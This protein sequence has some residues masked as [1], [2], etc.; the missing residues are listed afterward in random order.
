[1][2]RLKKISRMD[3]LSDTVYR[4]LYDS[5]IAGQ[6]IAGEIHNENE[7]AEQLGVSR[8]PV[9]EALRQ[10][11]SEG[12]VT[13][14]PGRGF[15]VNRFSSRDIEQI[16]KLRSVLE[17]AIVEEI[18]KNPEKYNFQKADSLHRQLCQENDALELLKI[19][20][21]YHVALCALGGNP[22]MEAVLNKSRDVTNIFRKGNMLDSKRI[23]QI[24]AEHQRI[25]DR[26]KAGNVKGAKTAMSLHMNKSLASV[27][28]IH[29]SMDNL[30]KE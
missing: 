9:R 30:L 28:K 22:K 5:I 11:S 4:K 20:K 16:Y 13:S 21:D 18:A 8:T 29:R 12:F 15:S 14:I 1:M 24:K 7:L 2:V 26:L 17:V 19:D 25:H 6:M 27:L 10:L 23:T 3:S